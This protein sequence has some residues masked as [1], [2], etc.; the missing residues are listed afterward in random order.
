MLEKKHRLAKTKDVKETFARGRGFF[1][2]LFS[3]RFV[4]RPAGVSRFTFVVSTKVGKNATVR[5]RL[6]RILRELVRRRLASFVPGDYAVILKP[7]SAKQPE[8]A[9]REGLLALCARHRLIK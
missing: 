8:A 4:A 9:V 1:S 6:K 7:A 5:N 2:P 3:L